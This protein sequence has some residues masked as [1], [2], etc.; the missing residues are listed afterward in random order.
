MLD[1]DLEA[2]SLPLDAPE[3][4]AACILLSEDSEI[5]R[6]TDIEEII[7]SC[8]KEVKLFKQH[9]HTCTIKMLTLL[10][11]VSEYVEL[12]AQYKSSKACKWPHLQAS[13]I[14]AYQMGRGVYF[15]HQICHHALYLLKFHHLPP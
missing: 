6:S 2:T 15:A 12:C 10:T 7:Q 11:A 9:N 13:M 5:A 1:L 3:I 4:E 8:L 14:T